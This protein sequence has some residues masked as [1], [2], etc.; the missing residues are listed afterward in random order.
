MN[1]ITHYLALAATGLS[2]ALGLAACTASN[3]G[4][5]ADFD[6]SVNFRNYRTW[7]WYPKQANDTEGGPARGYES[8]TDQRIRAAVAA[9]LAKKSLT[10][11]PA[12]TTPDVYIA[13]SVRVETKQQVSSPYG[14][15]YP[16][17]GYY[18]RGLYPYGGSGG[19][20]NYKA[21]TVVIDVVDAHR[22]EL[23]WRGTG[24]AQLDKNNLSEPETFRIVS[25]IL[26]AY[27]P[28]DVRR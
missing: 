18:G 10:E 13:Y 22:K 20:Y 21:G 7:A 25:S 1:R 19:V 27:P 26:G 8:F 11:A 9:E 15:G 17:G 4:V 16:Y 5:A 2:L 14:Y 24:Q 28:T 6:H 3:V 12:G 23:A